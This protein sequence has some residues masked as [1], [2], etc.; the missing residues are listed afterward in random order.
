[1]AD[2][3][4][5]VGEF[6]VAARKAIALGSVAILLYLFLCEGSVG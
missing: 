3:D 1:M 5:V 4:L 2:G 6:I